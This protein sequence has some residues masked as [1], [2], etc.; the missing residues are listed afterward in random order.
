MILPFGFKL[1]HL[2]FGV[3]SR[4]VFLTYQLYDDLTRF[5][6]FERIN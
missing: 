1:K 2:A 4:I 3:K 5:R 6:D